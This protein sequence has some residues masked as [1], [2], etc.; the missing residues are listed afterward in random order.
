M[1]GPAPLRYGRRLLLILLLLAPLWWPHLGSQAAGEEKGSPAGTPAPVAVLTVSDAI[2]P[3]TADYI[4]RGLN[5]AATMGAQLVVLQMDTPG[6]LDTAMRE[7]IKDIIASPVPVATFV[8]PSG[9]RAASAGTYILYA[10]HVAAM[11]PGTNL[12]AATP[13]AIGG[14]GT[15]SPGGDQGGEAE[16]DQER[17]GTEKEAPAGDALTRKQIEDA[18]AYIRSLAQMRGRNMEWAERAVREAV[19]LP[20]EEAAATNVVDLVARDLADLLAQI[21]GRRIVLPAGEITLNTANAPTVAIDPDWRNRFL[22]TVTNPSVAY[23]LM[24]IGVYGLLLEFYNPGFFV[25][26]VTGAICLLLALYAFHLLPVN[27]V[28][29]GLILLGVGFM[30]AELMIPSFGILGIGGVVAFVIGSVMLMDTSAP[31][32]T[33]PWPLIIVVTLA[34]VVFL[35]GVIGMALKAR[36]RPVVAGAEEMVGALGKAITD[37]DEQGRG[38]IMV[39][40]ENW[41]AKSA[42]PIHQGQQVRVVAINGLELDVE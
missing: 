9:A 40:S 21:D 36:R 27:Y 14:P 18:T 32:F 15:P 8:Y 37:F 19:S 35:L 13:V 25:P 2:G 3:A 1:V 33:L 4:K 12:G 6:G 24:L 23:I 41:K 5:R 28:G 7:I 26:G 29:V 39:H 10:S 34:T 16:N 42:K 30:T 17:E 22:A 31:E 11:A 20:A 38:W